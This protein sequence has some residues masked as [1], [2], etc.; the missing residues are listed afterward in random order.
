MFKIKE[1]ELNQL[2]MNLK[3]LEEINLW[4]QNELNLVKTE[5]NLTM[6]DLKKANQSL[7]KANQSLKKYEK[8]QKKKIIKVCVSTAIVSF[9]VG[10]VTGIKIAK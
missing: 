1:S 8:E 6:N 4:Q 7:Q 5:L 9:A 2:E 10:F 3:K